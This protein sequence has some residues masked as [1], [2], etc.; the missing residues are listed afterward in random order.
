MRIH[1][2]RNRKVEETMFRW[3]VCCCK[4]VSKKIDYLAINRG[5]AGR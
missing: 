4:L 2:D 3:P 1:T 5:A